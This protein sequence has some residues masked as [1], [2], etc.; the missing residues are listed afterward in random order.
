LEKVFCGFKF[1]EDKIKMR[2]WGGGSPYDR[3][4]SETMI[5][6]DAESNGVQSS[7]LMLLNIEIPLSQEQRLC[8]L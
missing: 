8:A 5:L 3:Q 6:E 2:K 4:G 7:Q 1:E